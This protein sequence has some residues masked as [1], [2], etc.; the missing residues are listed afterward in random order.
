MIRYLGQMSLPELSDYYDRYDQSHLANLWTTRR[1]VNIKPE[2]VAYIN[3]LDEERD[4]YLR[5]LPHT[6]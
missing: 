3:T 5:R 4:E 6:D 1:L 2:V